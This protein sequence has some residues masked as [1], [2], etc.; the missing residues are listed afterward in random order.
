MT[1]LEIRHWDRSLIFAT[2]LIFMG[3]STILKVIKSF[4]AAS[5]VQGGCL[6][7]IAQTP[8]KFANQRRTPAQR[9]KIDL[10]KTGLTDA[11]LKLASKLRYPKKTCREHLWWTNGWFVYCSSCSVFRYL[12][13]TV[14]PWKKK[15]WCVCKANEKK[16]KRKRKEE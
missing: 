6:G 3:V 5:D 2:V 13:Q 4:C 16:S 10:A 8:D 7:S 14:C 15:N 12:L 11:D 1:V 9:P